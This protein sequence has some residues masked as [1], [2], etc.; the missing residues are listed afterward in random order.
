VFLFM[1]MEH[2]TYVDPESGRQI[3]AVEAFGVA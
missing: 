1:L 3:S 2:T